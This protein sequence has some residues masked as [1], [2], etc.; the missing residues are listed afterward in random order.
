MTPDSIPVSNEDIIGILLAQDEVDN[1]VED[2][3]LEDFIKT[4]TFIL[5]K[6]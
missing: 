2:D 3:D 1:H 5:Y 6:K 4:K